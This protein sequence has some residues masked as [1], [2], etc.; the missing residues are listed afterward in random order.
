[1]LQY[2]NLVLLLIGCVQGGQVCYEHIGCFKDTNPWSGTI[3]RLIGKLPD[4]PEHI[5]TRLLLFTPENPNNFQEIPAL[6]PTDVSTTNFKT[7]RKTRF[8]I[9]GFI[10]N[11]DD[12][13]L[14][15]MCK[16]MLK[17]EDV[18]CICVDWRGG[19]HT[20]YSQ[21][22]NNIRVVGAQ[23]ANFLMFLNTKY[24]YSMSNVHL[25]GHSLGAHTAGEAGKRMP[26]IARITGLDPAGPFFE[27]TPPEVRLDPS[28]AKFVDVIHSDTSPLIP[29]MGYGM[30]QAVG[31]VDFY[32]NGGENMPGC[33]RNILTRVMDING[34][35]DG[36]N[37][38]IACNHLK[39][40]KYYTESILN[41][42]GFVGFP[43]SSYEAF[44]KGTG[45]PC[46]SNGCPVMGHYADLYASEGLSDHIYF[47][48]TGDVK[49]FARWRYRVTVKTIGSV[50]FFGSIQVS[51]HG[52]KGNT[53]GQTIASG[54]IKPGDTYTAFVDV[55]SDPGPLTTAT[56]I[57]NKGLLSLIPFT[58]GAEK[59][60]VQ[61]G[62]NGQTYE[63]C[64]RDKVKHRS[65]QSLSS[66]YSPMN[67]LVL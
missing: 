62:R 9:H 65:L 44:T 5:N 43:S 64:G 29:K 30:G 59:I 22:A 12:N 32:P 6:K 53:N 14:M 7:S 63:F 37:D 36:S 57:W 31:H 41:P 28:D 19:S 21:A 1:M 51:L 23:I 42:D 11:G 8:V 17:V 38:L 58:V 56:F 47:L 34:L 3:E 13:W 16:T 27:N 55:E 40:Y 24:G 54:F 26:G 20:L 10:S 52:I 67:K 15:D 66:C 50:S 18:N 2:C 39:S 49:P 46:P 48:N 60:S 61:Y 35:W 4:S 25:I 33:S 45:F